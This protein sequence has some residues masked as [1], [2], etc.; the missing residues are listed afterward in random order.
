MVGAL[1]HCKVAVE[2]QAQFEAMMRDFIRHVRHQEGCLDYHF[3]KLTGKDMEYIILQK[4]TTFH[5]L[6][7]HL[8]SAEFTQKAMK[9]VALS[10]GFL[11]TEVFQIV[12]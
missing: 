5:A 4:W 10:D 1:A 7:A 6:E 12:Y 2:N 3:A 9:L 11:A 8:S